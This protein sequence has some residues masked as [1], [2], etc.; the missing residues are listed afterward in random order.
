MLKALKCKADFLTVKCKF[1]ATR[2]PLAMFF[3]LDVM[4]QVGQQGLFGT[5][6]LRLL[7]GLGDIE[8]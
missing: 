6:L 1:N 4:A 3:M 2:E 8:V 5:D 7:D